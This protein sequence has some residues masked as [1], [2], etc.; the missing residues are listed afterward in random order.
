MGIIVLAQFS[1]YL[2]WT[3]FG[4]IIDRNLDSK[5]VFSLYLVYPEKD[6]RG[7]RGKG[8]KGG[9]DEGGRGVDNDEGEVKEDE[10]E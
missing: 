2:Q 8:R 3:W 6:V 9:R 1:Q 5:L 4:L 7:R 10:E